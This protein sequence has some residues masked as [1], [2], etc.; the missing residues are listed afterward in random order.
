MFLQPKITPPKGLT[1]KD[2]DL[3]DDIPEV[4]TFR[5]PFRT[6]G[7]A[8]DGFEG[9]VPYWEV[10]DGDEKPIAFVFS[11]DAAR[12]V[13]RMLNRRSEIA[14]S[15]PVVVTFKSAPIK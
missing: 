2:Q 6:E 4:E 14:S 13:A 5:A 11:L 12:E 15:A 8:P 3:I 1:A 10:M 9:L 7:G